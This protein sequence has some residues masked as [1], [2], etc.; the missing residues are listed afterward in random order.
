MIDLVSVAISSSLEKR[1]DVSFHV[2]Q[3]GKIA[4][5]AADLGRFVW[6]GGLK[7]RDGLVDFGLGGAGD[8]HV[9]IVLE[10]GFGDAEAET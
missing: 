7:A 4:D 2:G 1:F 5:V 9:G 10:G 6:V 3:L 8:D